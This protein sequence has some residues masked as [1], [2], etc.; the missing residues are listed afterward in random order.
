MADASG[1]FLP[2][3][4][5]VEEQSGWAGEEERKGCGRPQRGRDFK[6]LKEGGG[7]G[8]R[9]L[10]IEREGVGKQDGWRLA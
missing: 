6:A 2:F 9:K 4:L 10:D 1:P 3:F 7:G 5:L 8:G